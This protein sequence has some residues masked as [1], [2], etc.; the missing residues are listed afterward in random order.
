MIMKA[1]KKTLL[2]K[3]SE[4]FAKCRHT[5]NHRL[6]NVSKRSTHNNVIRTIFNSAEYISDKLKPNCQLP[7]DRIT[8][9]TQSSDENILTLL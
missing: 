4:I 6:T 5:N 7:E 8:R 2:N 3:R 1:D 9:E